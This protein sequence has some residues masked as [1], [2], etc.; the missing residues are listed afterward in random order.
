MLT[1]IEH[2]EYLITHND[3][4]VV[5][6]WGAII[7]QYTPPCLDSATN[8]FSKPQRNLAFNAAI[9]HDDGLL[10]SSIARREN[11]TYNEAINII[12]NNV[13]SF[14]IL[15]HEGSE[16]PFGRLGFFRANS[17][18]AT[19]FTPFKQEQALDQFFGLES[20]EF[21]SLEQIDLDN[22]RDAVKEAFS[23][24]R[25]RIFA[26][27]TWRAAASIIL[28]IVMAFVLSTPIAV[29]RK[30]QSYA[31]LSLPEIKQQ[32]KVTLS[33]AP[34][35]QPQ[36]ASIVTA[37]E[38]TSQGKYSLVVAT[39]STQKQVNGYLGMHSDISNQAKVVKKGKHLRIVIA[40]SDDEASLYQLIPTLPKA[41]S[42]SW[43][44]RD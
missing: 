38:S 31:S 20:F 41:Y 16:V 12:G 3:C 29:D 27:N 13:A 42:Q 15:L 32:P 34:T 18:G 30:S 37:D 36:V 9:S 40:Q 4:V 35:Q 39:F 2:I 17:S 25:N 11:V 33:D 8:V 24:R 22:K 5:P 1:M 23:Q 26:N 44:S 6:G 21:K 28:L 19:E 43:V 10:A 7:A 14:N